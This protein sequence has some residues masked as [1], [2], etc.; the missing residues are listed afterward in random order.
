MEC[1]VWR[2]SKDGNGRKLRGYISQ[3]EGIVH[4]VTDHEGTEVE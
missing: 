1:C 4:P 2:N 3:A